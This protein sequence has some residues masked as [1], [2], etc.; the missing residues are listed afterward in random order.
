MQAKASEFLEETK[1]IAAES[2]NKQEQMSLE[3]LEYNLKT[4]IDG[5]PYRKWVAMMTMTMTT[6]TTMMMMMQ[7]LMLMMMTMTPMPIYS[8]ID[9]QD[10]DYGDDDQGDASN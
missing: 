7:P 4:F 2:L 8:V 10:H 3:I 5:Y 9:G 1:N 6:T